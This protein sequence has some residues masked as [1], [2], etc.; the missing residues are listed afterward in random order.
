VRFEFESGI[1]S[2]CFSFIFVSVR[3]SCLLVSWCAGGRCG[4]ACRDEDRGRSRRP[5]A[6]DRGRSHRSDTRWPGDERLGDAVC[7]LYCARGDEEY[8]FLG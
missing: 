7:G 6:E 3:E 2:F 5:G 8:G 4:K 1:V